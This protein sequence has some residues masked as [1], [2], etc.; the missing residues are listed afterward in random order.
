MRISPGGPAVDP[1]KRCPTNMLA[2]TIRAGTIAVPAR[3]HMMRMLK[4][5]L[6]RPQF[7][8]ILELDKAIRSG[9]H[10]N[11]SSFGEAYEVSCK[12][13]QRDIEF[14]RSLG[15]PVEYDPLKKG[16]RYTD[17]TWHMPSLEL[18]E[19]EFL[20]LVMSTRIARAFR[21]TPLA[22]DLDSLLDKVLS[23]LHGPMTSDPALFQR[24]FSF[25]PMPSRPIRQEVWLCLFRAVRARRAVELSYRKPGDKKG[26]W[27]VVEPVHMACI[28][29]EWYLA[30][31][32]RPS[33]EMRNFALSRMRE[34]RETGDEFDPVPFDPDVYY[35]NRF[36]RFVGKPGESYHVSIR[37]MPGVAG[38][39]EERKWHPRQT[40]RH[41]KD[42]SVILSFPAPSLYEVERW[43]KEW[44][45]DAEILEP[46][47]PRRWGDSGKETA[48]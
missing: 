8:R 32:D 46:L 37:F 16:F 43:V 34:L 14:L 31:F 11:C 19:G 28:G 18:T 40:I 21:N 35:G 3:N 12:T 47:K 25:F 22:E 30:A 6:N 9:A 44:G 38:W 42:G 23:A 41:G 1:D 10:P 26:K 29:D 5:N 33:G 2:K 45:E 4:K 15:A 17:R 7:L 20:A 39:I 24:Y 36:G 13:V 48:L 27:R